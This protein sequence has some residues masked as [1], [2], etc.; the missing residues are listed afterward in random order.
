MDVNSRNGEKIRNF[1]ELFG[2]PCRNA[3]ADLDGSMQNVRVSVP[4]TY[5]TTFGS[6][7]KNRNG[8][9]VL[10]RDHPPFYWVCNSPSTAPGADGPQRGKGHVGRHC[11]YTY[12]MWC[13]SVP[14]LLRYRLKTTKMQKKNKFPIVTKIS[15]PRFSAS[16]GEGALTPK[17]EEDKDT[18]GTRVRPCKLW[19]E[20]ARGLSRNRW[21]NK[22]TNIQ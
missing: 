20:S 22:K 14:A 19:R 3:L 9:A 16:L 5:W 13:G 8:I 12:E 7:E 17:R 18:S 11:P 15:F 21:P 10:C 2:P 1:F 4:Y 6:A